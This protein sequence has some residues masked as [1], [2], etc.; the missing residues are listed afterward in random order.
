MKINSNIYIDNQ[1]VMI[2]IARK[3]I[4]CALYK[5]R[6][7]NKNVFVRRMKSRYVCN[8][9]SEKQTNK[10]T[11]LVR[12]S[13]LLILIFGLFPRATSAQEI[14]PGDVNNN[15]VV[16]GVDAL[17]I[18]IA[19]GETGPNRV[20]EGNTWQAY[21]APDP[22]AG[23]F[24][25]GLNYYYADINGDGEVKLEDIEEGVEDNYLQ[26]HGTLAPDGFEN[27]APGSGPALSIVPSASVV[28]EGTMV[29]FELFVGNEENP[30]EDF[31]GL[32]LQM[33]WNT[34]Q[35]SAFDEMLIIPEQTPWL[36]PTGENNFSY[37]M[38]D[39]ANGTA[40]FTIC[41]TN[42][43]TAEPGFG[44]VAAFSIIME[45]I[46]VGIE[47]DT[48]ILKVDSVLLISNELTPT[49]VVP[50]TAQVM[51]ST[52]PNTVLNPIEN[53]QIRI[54]PNPSERFTIV[55]TSIPI[56]NLMLFNACG[57]AIP[58]EVHKQGRGHYELHWS[59]QLPGGL[60]W[61]RGWSDK[62]YW[63]EKLIIHT[64]KTN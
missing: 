21:D 63:T 42:Q 41:R 10:H 31:Y 58:L 37:F 8:V 48:F 53:Q 40:D 47:E 16:N 36:D 3:V 11:L 43:E 57:Q 29:T 22:W 60:Y 5:F 33:S 23:T 64:P 9:E 56:D 61:L 26:T 32:A 30:V 46:V 1:F 51:M 17:Y 25:N 2:V 52:S 55:Q 13:L 28:G 12:L 34:A 14:W 50:D 15:G 27:A 35:G 59:D 45:D 54:Y 7:F 19:L 49:A 6:Q 44:K 24:P 20:L 4:D 39:D 18:G 62:N 38:A